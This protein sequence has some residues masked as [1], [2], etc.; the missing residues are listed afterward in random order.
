MVRSVAPSSRAISLFIFPRTTRSKTCRSRGLRWLTNARRWSSCSCLSRIVRVRARARSIAWSSVSLAT[1]F[2]RRSSAPALMTRT[3]VGISAWP[4]RKMMG[5]LNPRAFRR[6]C[7]SGPL[8]PGILISRRMQPGAAPFGRRFSSCSA[9]FIGLDRITRGT[10]DAA[11]RGPEGGIVVNDV[12]DSRH[13]SHPLV[14]GPGLN[15]CI[16]SAMRFQVSFTRRVTR[17]SRRAFAVSN[18]APISANGS[19]AHQYRQM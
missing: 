11:G 5:R 10:Q 16:S 12:N 3:V 7:N 8:M 9:E 1:G 13:E 17:P 14:S 19:D 18:R 15:P 2:V 6:S 4:V